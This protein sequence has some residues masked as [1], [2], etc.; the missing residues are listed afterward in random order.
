MSWGVEIEEN[1][2]LDLLVS[3]RAHKDD[4]RIPAV[5]EDMAREMG[6]GKILS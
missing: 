6:E 5:C 3:Y 4:P 1:S 2:E